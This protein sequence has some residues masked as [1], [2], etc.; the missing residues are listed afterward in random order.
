MY[1]FNK[2]KLI[3]IVIIISMFCTSCRMFATQ[4]MIDNII[5]GH[6]VRPYSVADLVPY[7]YK[8][9]K[10][11]RSLYGME[12][13][14][15]FLKNTATESAAKDMTQKE[16]DDFIF[17]LMIRTHNYKIIKNRCN[18]YLAQD[19]SEDDSIIAEREAEYKA[20]Y[21]AKNADSIETIKKYNNGKSDGMPLMSI[22]LKLD[23]AT[24]SNV[25][26]LY[27]EVE[28]D[29]FKPVV[30]SEEKYKNLK[31]GDTITIEVPVESDDIYN[32][33][34]E[35]IEFTYVAT[36]SLLYKED[37]EKLDSY[38][39]IAPSDGCNNS[40]RILNSYGK[41]IEIYAETKPLQFMKLCRVV[42]VSNF[43][44]LYLLMIDEE[45]LEYTT[46]NIIE[47]VLAGENL[48]YNDKDGVY[49]NFITTNPKGYIT[50]AISF[51]NL[52]VDNEYAF[53]LN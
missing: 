34:T 11:A 48:E 6:N 9:I 35:K 33:K 24:A 36:D 18:M 47:K 25:S 40:R 29:I 21:E 43:V 14:D 2:S 16:F 17:E 22:R 13:Q 26:P 19:G 7:S 12:L 45:L 51:T 50:S 10:N 37:K 44:S 42:E 3:S 20:Y 46:G 15:F 31:F 27:D 52:S 23:T 1:R 38:Y 32:T 53:T 8:E 49:A 28:C 5:P 41:T 30:I 4:R 39:F